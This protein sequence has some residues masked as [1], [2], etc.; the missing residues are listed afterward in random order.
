MFSYGSGLASCMYSLRVSDSPLLTKMAECLGNLPK[1]LVA[2]KTVP[3]AEFERTMKLREET[4]HLAPY[5]PVGDPT[6]LFPGTYYLTGVDEKHRRS[7]ARVPPQ[8]SGSS[9][10]E[11]QLR[12]PLAQTLA[13]GTA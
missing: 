12:S 9:G 4:H 6:Q 13:N 2:R 10:K 5:Q 7:Y 3:P 1:T 8:Q 11:A